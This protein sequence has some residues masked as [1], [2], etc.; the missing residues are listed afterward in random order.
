MCK[1]NFN[2][3][4][5]SVTLLYT[6]WKIPVYEENT[7]PNVFNRLETE[8]RHHNTLLVRPRCVNN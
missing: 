4:F 6:D 7:K 2:S 8:C 1:L 3:G 5:W